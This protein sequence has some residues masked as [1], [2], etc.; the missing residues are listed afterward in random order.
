MD[1]IWHIIVPHHVQN[2]YSIK[3]FVRYDFRAINKK[4]YL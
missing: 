1:D 2:D 4:N 3:Q